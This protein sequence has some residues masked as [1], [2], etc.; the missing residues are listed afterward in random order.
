MGSICR[1]Q[2]HDWKQWAQNDTQEVPSEHQE[3]LFCCDPDWALA[4]DT[5]RCCRVSLLRDKE[6]P[7]GHGPGQTAPG[8]PAWAGGWVTWTPEIPSHLKPPVILGMKSLKHPT[9]GCCYSYPSPNFLGDLLFI[10]AKSH[11]LTTRASSGD[12]WGH[13][14]VGAQPRCTKF[15]S[16]QTLSL[17][18]FSLHGSFTFQSTLFQVCQGP[19]LWASSSQHSCICTEILLYIHFYHSIT[20]RETSL[21]RTSSPLCPHTAK[22]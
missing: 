13:L 19:R 8:H 3:M 17:L 21:T 1:A 7:S 15:L 2:A 22:F 10:C 6:K 12:L 16:C 20:E 11:H 18:C 9:L 14:Q 5:Q 4:Q